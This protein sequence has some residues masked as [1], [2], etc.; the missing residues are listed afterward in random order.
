MWPHR[1]KPTRLP[2]PGIFQARTLE[3]V[4]ISFSNAWKWKVK[5]KSL[6]CVRLFA[7]PWTAAY[8]APPSMGFSRQEYRSRVPSP[9]P[10]WQLW[11]KKNL[12]HLLGFPLPPHRACEFPSPRQSSSLLANLENTLCHLQNYSDLISS[13][14]DPLILP[15]QI[16]LFLLSKNLIPWVYHHEGI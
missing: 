3:W 15:R 2:V 12:Q 10:I 11:V 14:K 9:S 5:V 8:Q 6:S 16:S 13:M 7:T 4:A 1:W